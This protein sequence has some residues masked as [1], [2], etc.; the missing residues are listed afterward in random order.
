MFSAPL[1]SAFSL[2]PPP[3][4]FQNLSVSAFSPAIFVWFVYFVVALREV[5]RV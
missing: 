3:L 5:D 1:H 2:L 4:R